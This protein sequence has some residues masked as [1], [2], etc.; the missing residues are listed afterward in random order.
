MQLKLLQMSNKLRDYE[1]RCG[2]MQKFIIS[3]VS[4]SE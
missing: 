3:F 4:M 1:D 2:W